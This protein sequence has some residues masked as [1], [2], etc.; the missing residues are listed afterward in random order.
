VQRD[1]SLESGER[2]PG[3]TLEEIRYDHRARYDFAVKYLKEH[4]RDEQL[5]F[6][7]DAFCGNGYGTYILSTGLGCN[8]LG[9]D[10]SGDAVVFAARHYANEK[11]FYAHKAFPFQ[12]PETT[13]D[14]ITCY[15]SLEH[16]EKASQL[17]KE[18][19]KSLKKEGTLFLSVPNEP[20]LLRTHTYPPPAFLLYRLQAPCRT[21]D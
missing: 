20:C 11:T 17:V 12:L 2:Q 21:S 13:F 6:G 19:G 8:M 14:F 5:S 7:L 15:E 18:I 1:F 4:C 10:G 3:E 16:V 9:I